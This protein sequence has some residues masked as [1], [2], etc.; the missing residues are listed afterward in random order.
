MSTSHIHK[1]PVGEASDGDEVVGM[2]LLSQRVADKRL[3]R[4]GFEPEATVSDQLKPF[5][6]CDLLGPAG[7][8]KHPGAVMLHSLLGRWQRS[9][10]TYRLQ[11]TWFSEMRLRTPHNT[12]R[13]LQCY[14]F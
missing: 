9:G 6:A 4:T 10:D 12:G 11:P 13:N 1:F 8:P 7:K 2:S 5:G 14:T 3:H